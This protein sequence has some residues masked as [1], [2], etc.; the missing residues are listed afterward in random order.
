MFKVLLKKPASFETSPNQV[1]SPLKQVLDLKSISFQVW[2]KNKVSLT[3]VKSF[4]Q[5]QIDF[6]FI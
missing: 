1:L 5:N 2:V 6:Q 4:E 3:W